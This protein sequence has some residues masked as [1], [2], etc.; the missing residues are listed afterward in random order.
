MF[1]RLFE[2]CPYSSSS[3][4]PPELRTRDKITIYWAISSAHRAY[5]T[6]SYL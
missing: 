1:M 5:D 2:L 6:S 3:S 4:D